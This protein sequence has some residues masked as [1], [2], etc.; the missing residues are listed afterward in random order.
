MDQLVRPEFI[1]SP[2]RRRHFQMAIG[3]AI[4][5]ILAITSWWLLRPHAPAAAKSAAPLPLVT[6]VSPTLGEVSASV[7]LTGLISARNDMPIGTEGDVGRIAAVLVEAGDRVHRGQVLARLNPITGQSGVDSAEASLAEATA[8]AAVAQ[9]EWRRAEQGP[10]LFSKEEDDRRR[11]T[12]LASDAKVKAAEAQLADMRNRLAH[13]TVIAPTDGIVL[14]RTAEVGQIA[15]PGTSVLFRLA[16]DGQVEM[17]GQV[18]ESDLPKLKIGQRAQVRLDGV[19]KSFDG[20]IW[21]L[22][23]VIDS[24]TRQG[25]VRIAL[26][27]DNLDLRPGA[28]AR[29]DVHVDSVRG[30]LL[31]QT[32]VLADDKGN[33]VLVVGQDN[34]V[35]RR[36]VTVAGARSE[37]LLVSAGLAGSERVIAIAGAFLRAGESVLIARPST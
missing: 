37:G 3:A 35:Q 11:T 33:Y 22:G 17:R 8:N 18:A 15:V 24:N 19:A 27:S 4:L 30:V 20:Q 23:A 16:R 25:T 31:P 29:A 9:A 32:A 7:S 21:Q 36:D 6:V 34:K 2:P 28:F 13:T 26:P 10:D 5:G 1:V 14:T 12:A